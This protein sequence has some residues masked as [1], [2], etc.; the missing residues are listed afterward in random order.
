MDSFKVMVL[1]GI[2]K[3]ELRTKS[4]EIPKLKQGRKEGS[5]KVIEGDRKSKTKTKVNII[6]QILYWD[7]SI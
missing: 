4:F 5:I 3:T 7:L 1:G 2:E 6:Y